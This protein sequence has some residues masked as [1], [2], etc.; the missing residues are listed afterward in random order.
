MSTFKALNLSTTDREN[1]T[2]C[3]NWLAIL[4]NVRTNL[5]SSSEDIFIPELSL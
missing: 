4:H 5:L 2:E 1:Q 3:M